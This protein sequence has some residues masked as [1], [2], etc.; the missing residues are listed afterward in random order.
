M[1]NLSDLDKAVP[2]S[3]VPASW[4]LHIVESEAGHTD[5]FYLMGLTLG[6]KVGDLVIVETDLGKDLGTAVNEMIMLE[7]LEREQRQNVAYGDGGPLSP[8]SQDSVGRVKEG[9]I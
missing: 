2:L 6:I 8:G 9:D 1:P 4:P 3:S 5:L 7:V